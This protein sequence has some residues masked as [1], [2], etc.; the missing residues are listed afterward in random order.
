MAKQYGLYLHGERNSR[1]SIFGW[2]GAALQNQVFLVSGPYHM[3]SVFMR[4]LLTDKGSIIGRPDEGTDFLEIITSGIPDAITLQGRLTEV[5]DD[6]A[7][8][9]QSIQQRSFQSG[10]IGADEILASYRLSRIYVSSNGESASASVELTNSA[11]VTVPGILPLSQFT[12]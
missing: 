12:R 4:V 6:A 3:S 5:L 11:G 2:T 7:A 1:R 10:H 9:T 8:Q